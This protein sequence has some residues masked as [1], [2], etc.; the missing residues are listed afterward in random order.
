MNKRFIMSAVALSAIIGLNFS[1]SADS[2]NLQR[3]SGTNR[4]ETGVE[5]SRNVYKNSKK[6]VIV[7]GEEYADA[8]SGG[9]IS[10]LEDIPLFMAHK[11]GLE[12]NVLDEL[13][14]LKVE[15][16]VLVGGNAS[17]SDKVEKELVKTFKVS[18]IAGAN[19]EGT[20][21]EVYR[22]LSKNHDIKTIGISNG[23]KFTDSLAAIPYLKQEK[24]IL[25][26]SGKKDIS[27]EIKNASENKKV[28]VFGGESSISKKADSLPNVMR[29]AGKNRF[30]TAEKIGENFAKN[31]GKNLKNIDNVILTSGENYPDSLSSIS[32]SLKYDSP[33]LFGGESTL[34]KLGK[35]DSGRKV[36][37]VGGENSVSKNIENKISGKTEESKAKDSE[38]RSSRRGS[39]R[40]SS[41]SDEKYVNIP[42]KLFLKLVNKNIDPE[43][44]DDAKV[45]KEDM[46]KLKQLSVYGPNTVD[47]T[48]VK[49]GE[50]RYEIIPMH[51]LDTKWMVSRGMKSIEGIQY[52][53][54]LEAIE[55]SECEIEDITP[56]KDLKKLKYIEIDRNRIK[57]L[58]PLEGLTEVDH[59]KLYNNLITDVTPLSK[60]T[61]L[62]YLDIHF[63]TDNN[64]ENGITDISSLKTLKVLEFL[65]VSANHLKNI[66]VLNELPKLNMTDFSNNNITDYSKIEDKVVELSNLGYG[67]CGFTGQNYNVSKKF[68]VPAEGGKIRIENPYKGTEGTAQKLLDSPTHFLE[69]VGELKAPARGEKRDIFEEDRIIKSYINE[70][71]YDSE[72]DEFV[73]DIL[74]NYSDNERAQ[75]LGFTT[76]FSGRG[77]GVRGITVSQKPSSDETE[78]KMDEETKKF[79]V[80]LLNSYNKFDKKYK[81]LTDEAAKDYKNLKYSDKITKGDMKKLRRFIVT[82]R[83]IDHKLVEPLKYAT[84]LEA[85][86]CMLNDK[87]LKRELKNFD[88]LRDCSKL[89]TLY[90][91]NQDYEDLEKSEAVSLDSLGNNKELED[92]RMNATE[93]SNIT[94]IKD[95][96][97]KTLSLEENN[98][99]SV[100]NI[101]GMETLERLDL[102]NNKIFSLN[103]LENLKN[104]RTLY[105]YGNKI[106]TL[107]PLYELENLEALLAQDNNIKNIDGIE[108]M[109]LYRFRIQGNP[110]E[111]G[112]M[113][114]IMKMK[115]L[116]QICVENINLDEF[117]WMQA[118]LV[119]E[120]NEKIS[121]LEENN[122]REE[123]FANL[124]LEYEVSKDDIKDN[125]VTVENKLKYADGKYISID[126]NSKV[127]FND[128]KM[129]L[130][131]SG[132]S[133]DNELKFELNYDE[134]NY[135]YEFDNGIYP[136]P[137][138][139][140]G[141]ITITVK[142]K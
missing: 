11:N 34:N 139:I 89:K 97:L 25:L 131:M 83:N 106:S 38:S 41:K 66:D 12:K 92:F 136:Q 90:Y 127:T 54:N 22:A 42:D 60:L 69:F 14:R 15:E 57:D 71:S 123:Y 56:L 107:K 46:L 102:E 135:N 33:I 108:N 117:N 6:A 75:E 129:V 112:Y 31:N 125:K 48:N 13:N 103:G 53:K 39:G 16:V 86:E 18:R 27:N 62:K 95:L 137:A 77:W 21:L 30:E 45:T 80:D 105:V 101:S 37:I 141:K 4:Y 119:R 121:D 76:G 94:G 142:V 122:P 65:D 36:F 3:I 98:V 120:D 59:L 130:D 128:D 96:K 87:S 118:N 70:I 8:L 43:R 85:F 32:L 100:F 50:K 99:M 58:T 110:L 5:V 134:E 23:Y 40:S 126:K 111:E 73:I 9:N 49:P 17:I 81:N 78:I 74:P 51:K 1:A 116:N 91:L 82:N 64:G 88:F 72:K 138:H 63:N 84:N 115:T 104:L 26:L 132:L 24:G 29:I 35:I 140:D 113:N 2:G 79:Y 124:N 114:T 19:R 44:A 67:H 52:A 93:T 47:I 28:V 61:K 133:E 68:E 55:I 109:N 10:M 7:S 20:S